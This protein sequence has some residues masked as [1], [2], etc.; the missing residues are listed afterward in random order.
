MILH[1]TVRGEGPGLRHLTLS[2]PRPAHAL[3]RSI[4]LLARSTA[5]TLDTM[6]LSGSPLFLW[7]VRCEGKSTPLPFVL[8]LT[9]VCRTAQYHLIRTPM[10]EY[11]NTKSQ[12]SLA[13]GSEKEVNLLLAETDE[14]RWM[15]ETPPFFSLDRARKQCWPSQHM[16]CIPVRYKESLPQA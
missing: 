14:E 6:M 16:I 3:D 4:T 13:K 5:T 8:S 9:N 15:Y 10:R 12:A 2:P 7:V 11:S 1:W